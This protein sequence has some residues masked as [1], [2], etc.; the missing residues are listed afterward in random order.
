MPNL[1]DFN[2]EPYYTV[3]EPIRATILEIHAIIRDH[4]GPYSISQSWGSGPQNATWAI[5]PIDDL[6]KPTFNISIDHT[7]R[8]T[9]FKNYAL[10]KTFAY[11]LENPDFFE[12]VKQFIK[13]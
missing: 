12:K 2:L 5:R 1:H 4:L 8:I 3:S 7:V 11:D 10:A 9:R 6:Y 13:S